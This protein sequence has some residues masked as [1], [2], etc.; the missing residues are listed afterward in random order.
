MYWLKQ[1]FKDAKTHFRA[2]SEV[3]VTGFFSI[4]PLVI[5]YI[6]AN[7]RSSNGSFTPVTNVVGRGQIFI[8]CYSFYG[9]I[10]WLA[11]C[12]AG[13]AG[14]GPRKFFGFVATV[15]IFFV[16]AVLGVDPTLS[17]ILNPTIV[18]VS[19][20]M[21]FVFLLINYLLLFY[22]N[23]EPPKLDEVYERGAND[24]RDKLRGLTQHE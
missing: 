23:V 13:A 11:F 7:L 15:S 24:M 6:I 21:Y 22:L 10:F 1:Y 14:S 17:N 3:V 8:L 16:V 19:Y 4:L 5:P 9:T 20:L 18:N 12:R 2:A